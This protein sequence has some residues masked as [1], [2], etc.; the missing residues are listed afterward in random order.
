M[1]GRRRLEAPATPDHPQ[2]KQPAGQRMEI[3]PSTAKT[4]LLRKTDEFHGLK[5]Q[6]FAALL[7][8]VDV[9]QLAN[10]SPEK[11]RA[12]IRAILIDV[13]EA[14][15]VALSTTEQETLL[16]DICNDV[17]GYGPLEPLLARD[18]INDIMVN[19]YDSIYI[20][21]GGRI[22]KTDIRFRDNAQLL[23]VCQRIVNQ[24]A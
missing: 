21:V 7:D 11:A 15:K 12:E 8:I 1:F 5:R 16:D 22:Q 6:A 14:R 3:M 17:L 4:F 2:E 18:D 23:G 10:L 20:E 13:I 19:G 9:A 24:T